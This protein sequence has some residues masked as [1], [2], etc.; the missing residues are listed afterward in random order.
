M[1]TLWYGTFRYSIYVLYLQNIAS[2][3]DYFEHAIQ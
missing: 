3:S 2:V 1:I